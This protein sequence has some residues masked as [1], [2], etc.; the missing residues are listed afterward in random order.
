MIAHEVGHGVGDVNFREHPQR[1]YRDEFIKGSVDNQMLNEGRAQFNAAQVRAE[2]NAAGG[3]DIGI[4]GS[5][6]PAF[7]QAHDDFTTGKISHAQ[8]VDR[9][10]SLMRSEHVSVPPHSL[11]PDFYREGAEF[12]WDTD[13]DQP[14]PPPRRP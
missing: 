2:L 9:M 6:T 7:Q 13:V 8:A 10:G 5:Q 14:Q 1:L 11:Y 3:P 12:E 4:P